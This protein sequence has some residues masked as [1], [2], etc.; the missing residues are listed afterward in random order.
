MGHRRLA[1]RLARR[2]LDARLLQAVVVAGSLGL[3]LRDVLVEGCQACFTVALAGL[4]DG[5]IG[6]Q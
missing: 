4:I 1:G 5:Q 3:E 6:L 2:Q